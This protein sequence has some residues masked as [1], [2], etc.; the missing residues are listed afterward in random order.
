M[1]SYGFT[2]IETVVSIFILTILFSVGVSLSKLGS[3]LSH[4]IENTAY[5]YEIQNLLS[6]GKAV[7]KEKNKNGKITVKSSENEIHFIEGW[8][9]IEKIINL[10]K[11]IKI[12]NNDI[13]VIITSDGK[14]S[15]GDTIKLIDKYGQR[16][17]ITIRVGVDLIVIKDG[18]FV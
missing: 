13:S 16:Q 14:I 7:C 5:I 3:S 6:Y 18:E 15:Q 4:D 1:K 12:I 8:D 17:D 10:P 2:L 11:E 9:N